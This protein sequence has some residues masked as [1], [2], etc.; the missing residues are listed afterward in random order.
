MDLFFDLDGTL[1]DPAT[2][3]CS[4]L[5]HALTRMGRRPPP[6]VDLERFIGPPL[7]GTFA[8][9]LATTDGDT[10]EAAVAHYRERFASEGLYE[11]EVYPDVPAGLAA[12]CGDGHRLWV[13]TSKPWVY[14]EKII[15]HFDLAPYFARIFGSELSGERSDKSELIAF[16]LAEE[17]LDPGGVWMIGDRAQDIAGGRANGTATAGVLWGYGSRRE[18]RGAKPDYLVESMNALRRR[19]DPF[20]QKGD[21]TLS[22]TGQGALK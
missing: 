4:C 11:N 5:S 18:L 13:V 16:V 9:L 14:A 21:R 19:V 6:M 3:I 2:G 17:G 7:R 10:L 1:T 20:P 15:R 8:E 22:I 12:L